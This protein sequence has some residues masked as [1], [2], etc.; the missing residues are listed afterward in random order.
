MCDICPTC[1]WE[2]DD[3]E[4]GWS[5]ANGCF[6]GVAREVWALHV[7]V[8]RKLRERGIDPLARPHPLQW[9]DVWD[10]YLPTPTLS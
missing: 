5:S 2:Q 4:G 1:G 9:C 8:A 6:V 7:A 10:S 3:L